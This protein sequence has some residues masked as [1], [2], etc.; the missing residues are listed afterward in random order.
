MAAMLAILAR[1]NAGEAVISRAQ[2]AHRPGDWCG[3]S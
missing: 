2:Q 3:R 1:L